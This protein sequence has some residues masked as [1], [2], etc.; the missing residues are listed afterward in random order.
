MQKIHRVNVV[1]LNLLKSR[2][3]IEWHWICP[4][5]NRHS[6]STN[7][8]KRNIG[9]TL[10]NDFRARLSV[11]MKIHSRF[12]AR[13]LNRFTHTESFQPGFQVLSN[14]H[15]SIQRGTRF[16]GFKFNRRRPLCYLQNLQRS[17]IFTVKPSRHQI[18]RLPMNCKQEIKFI[19]L[20]I[21]FLCQ[22]I[23]QETAWESRLI[24]NEE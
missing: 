24:E 23:F 18:L 10:E 6:V 16:N 11:M 14:G 13:P 8:E 4:C 12:I 15:K 22:C 20:F 2:E 17:C 19:S 7:V 3:I 21:Y 9:D 5:R 1:R